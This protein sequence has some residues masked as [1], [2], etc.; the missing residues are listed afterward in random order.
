MEDA[1]YQKTRALSRRSFPGKSVAVLEPAVVFAYVR[2]KE[3]PA[4]VSFL[5]LSLHLVFVF[6]S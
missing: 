6:F 4:H 3:S 5:C 2:G 1:A